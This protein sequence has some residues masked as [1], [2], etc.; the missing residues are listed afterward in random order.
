MT[1]TIETREALRRAY[2]DAREARRDSFEFN[3]STLLMDYTKYLLE[4][5]DSVLHP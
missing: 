1:F 2:N 3:G 4:Y 5:L